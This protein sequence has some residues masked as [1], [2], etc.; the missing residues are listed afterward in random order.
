MSKT[1]GWTWADHKT[2]TEIVKELN[3]TASFLDKIQKYR[4]NFCNI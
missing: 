4:R 1:A 2:N 3:I